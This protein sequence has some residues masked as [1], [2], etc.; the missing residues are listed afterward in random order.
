MKKL[1]F[2][3]LTF[4]SISTFAQD[5]KSRYQNLFSESKLDEIQKLLIEWEKA[6]PTNPEMFIAN[7]NFYLQK[8]QEEVLQLDTEPG[9]GENLTISDT[10]SGAPV[11][12]IYGKIHYN[13]ELFDKSQKY[14]IDGIKVNPDRLDM[15][16][17][18]I[19]SLRERGHIEEHLSEIINVINKHF[20]DKPTWL[21]SNNDKLEDSEK[22]FKSAIQD[23]NYA[24]FNLDPPYTK[25]IKAISE[26]MIKQY[27]N[28]I[29][30]YS[31][32]GVCHLMD[33][34]WND[35]LSNF[36]KAL[37]INQEDV[38]VISNIAYTYRMKD[39]LKSAI[40]YY[41]KVLETDDEEAKNFAKQQIENLKT[42]LEK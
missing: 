20:S 28:D 29:E 19:H 7:F 38:I 35:A 25:G 31:N 13:D 14:L 24:L 3:I 16:F 4:L 39:D 9:G 40:K 1:F 12:Y 17:G 32:I 23:Y 6:E 10:A 18:R 37:K 5:F 11:G 26:K 15:Y 30:N 21:W 36:E 2:I 22:M 34:N 41:E 8:S 42:Q 27:P 33:S